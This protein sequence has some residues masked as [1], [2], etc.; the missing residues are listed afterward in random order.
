MLLQV[1]REKTERQSLYSYS[2][3]NIAIKKACKGIVI[4]KFLPEYSSL[5]HLVQESAPSSENV[6]SS[7]F[8]QL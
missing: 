7:Q 8:L 4:E 5:A 2:E 1:A 6:F 3:L